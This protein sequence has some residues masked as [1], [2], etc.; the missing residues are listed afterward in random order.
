MNSHK[1]PHIINAD[2]ES[3]IRK[4]DKSVDNSE[5]SSTLKIGEHIPC[6]YSMSTISGFNQIEEKHV[7]M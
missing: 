4:I 2:I 6:G 3:F 5:K 7:N 1:M